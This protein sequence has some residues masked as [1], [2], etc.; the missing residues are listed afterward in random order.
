[1]IVVGSAAGIVIYGLLMVYAWQITLRVTAFAAV[2]VLLGVL[3][4]VG[5]TRATT[6]LP[7]ALLEEPPGASPTPSK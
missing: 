5:Y 6:P 3:A 1:M 2:L 7:E 4:W